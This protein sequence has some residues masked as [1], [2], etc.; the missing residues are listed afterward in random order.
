MHSPPLDL[1]NL[2][3][4]LGL[5]AICGGLIGLE[6]ERLERAAGLRTHALV[7]VG[8]AL[9]MI[10]STYGFP[11][12]TNGIDMVLDPSRI[13]AQVISGIGF[14]GAGVIIFRDNVVRGL[15]TAATVWAVAGLGLAC[16][17]GLWAVAICA[18]A[19]MLVIQAGLKPVERRLFRHHAA[20]YRVL[21]ETRAP[22][23]VMQ[24]LDAMLNSDLVRLHSLQFDRN[25]KDNRDTVELNLIADSPES[26]H[27]VVQ[28]LQADPNV[29]RVVYRAG[30]GQVRPT[31]RPATIPSHE[32]TA[33]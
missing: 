13:A 29:L 28:N 32:R 22:Q 14:L 19:F 7:S 24:G 3:L 12:A 20:R 4:R 30:S 15:T 31:A 18:T 16:G 26:I 5:A 27:I 1:F 8:S 9:V 21:V 6:R 25:E 10:V 11:A 33:S 2:I 23:S 17:A